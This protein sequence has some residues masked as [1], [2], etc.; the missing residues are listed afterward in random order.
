MMFD[1]VC[2]FSDPVEADADDSAIENDQY[3]ETC[4]SPVFAQAIQEPKEFPLRI[5]NKKKTTNKVS[6]FRFNERN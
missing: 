1:T 4:N 3:D 5:L 6:V 2:V